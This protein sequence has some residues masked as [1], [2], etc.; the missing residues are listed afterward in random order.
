MHPNPFGLAYSL[1]PIDL[2]EPLMPEPHPLRRLTTVIATATLTLALLTAH[3]LRGWTYQLPPGT[4]SERAVVAAEGWYSGLDRVGL[5]RPFEAMHG[6]W[7]TARQAV[8]PSPEG[9][10]SRS[11]RANSSRATG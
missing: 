1:S 11:A 4:W 3:A 6:F 10:S 8:Q 5:N 9:N 2:P 7:Q